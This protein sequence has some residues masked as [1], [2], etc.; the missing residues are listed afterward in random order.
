MSDLF[1]RLRNL[2]GGPPPVADEPLIRA[3]F[4]LLNSPAPLSEEEV[5]RR[6]E[7]HAARRQGNTVRLTPE[8][9]A[10]QKQ[11]A[12]TAYGRMLQQQ[13]PAT[14][15]E[16]IAEVLAA[17][18]AMNTEG[19]SIGYQLGTSNR[20]WTAGLSQLKATYPGLPDDLYQRALQSGTNQSFR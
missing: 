10:A 7:R 1:Y 5:R 9:M 14:P 20:P 17:V 8:D 6:D 19:Q 11:D 2:L 16:R 4:A 13:F 3:A 18:D 12:L 15:A